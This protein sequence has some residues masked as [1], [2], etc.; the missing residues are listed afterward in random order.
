MFSVSPPKVIIIVDMTYLEACNTQLKL[1]VLNIS[2]S[3]YIKFTG[4]DK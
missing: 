3:V 2:N 4:Y 1:Y